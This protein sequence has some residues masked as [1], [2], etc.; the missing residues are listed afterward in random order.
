MWCGFLQPGLA[1]AS[2]FLMQAKGLSPAITEGCFP[3]ALVPDFV[4]DLANVIAKMACSHTS[5]VLFLESIWP[6]QADL[7]AGGHCC[8]TL[9][10]VLC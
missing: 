8:G 5:G 4:M 2:G 1:L 10:P 3:S 9:Q 7:E 6:V